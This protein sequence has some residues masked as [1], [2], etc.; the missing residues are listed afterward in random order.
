MASI[1][2]PQRIIQDTP[3]RTSRKIKI[4]PYLFILPH[5]LFFVLFIGYPFF[6]G[7]YLSLFRYDYLQPGTNAFVGLQNYIDLFTQG[8]VVFQEFWNSLWNTLQFVVY[9]VPLLVII[10][11][12]LALLLNAK[13]PGVTVFRTIYF[14]PWVL[15][16]SVVGLLW[17][18]IFQSTGGLVNNYLALFHIDTPEWLS[19]LPWAWVAIVVATIWWT[20]G[21]NMIILLAALQNIPSELYEAASVDGANKWHL[22]WRIT[23]PLLRPILLFIVITSIIASF[24]LFGQPFIMTQGGPAM[25]S[26]GGATTPVMYEIYNNGI[27]RHFVGSAAAMSFVVAIIMIAISYTNFRLFRERT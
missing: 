16:V 1:L 15:S 17:W 4:T 14:A 13:I 23:L 5:L 3:R 22:L 11:L 24:N 10:P 25:P 19:T 8:T 6:N 21:F 27:V 12:L 9:S 20:M 2:Q 18:W 7:L 26:G